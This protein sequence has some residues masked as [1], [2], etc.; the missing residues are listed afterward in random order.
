MHTRPLYKIK[1][2]YSGEA[3]KTDIIE[4]FKKLLNFY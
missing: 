3:K 2:L 1:V 4:T